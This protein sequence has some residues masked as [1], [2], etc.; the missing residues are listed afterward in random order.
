MKAKSSTTPRALATGSRMA[1]VDNTGARMVQIVS[2]EQYHGVRRRQPK[3]GLGDL[4]IVSIKKGTPDMRR[5]LERAVVIRQKKEIRRPSGLRVSFEDNAMVLVND[6]NE[7][8]GTE[9][10]GP[11]AREVA[12]RFPKLGSMATL[13]V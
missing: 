9:I 13:I 4:A 2:V 6:R 3:L 8:K 1:C 12:E 7:P 5:K 10:K 11:V